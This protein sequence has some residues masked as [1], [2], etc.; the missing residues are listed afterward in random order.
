VRTIERFAGLDGKVE[1]NIGA[2]HHLERLKPEAGIFWTRR[3][4][5]QRTERG[6]MKQIEDRFQ[7]LAD[8]IAFGELIDIPEESAHDVN[9][10]FSLWLHRSR[11][12]PAE[13][14]E[15]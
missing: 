6:Y 11:I 15:T 9:L 8:R 12:Q 14:I 10:F 13:E 1:V 4:W 7:P 3:A 5:D 2:G